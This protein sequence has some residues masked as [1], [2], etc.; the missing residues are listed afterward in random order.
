LK[1]RVSLEG[2]LRLK[3]RWLK[4]W[5]RGQILPY[6]SISVRRTGGMGT[7]NSSGIAVRLYFGD[8]F[9]PLGRTHATGDARR[10]RSAGVDNG[11]V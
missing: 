3:T 6:E 7:E 8:V 5:V 11:T 1:S 2:Q 10:L 9:G 4:G